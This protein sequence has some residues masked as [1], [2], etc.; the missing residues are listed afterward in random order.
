[1]FLF[2]DGP[3][4]CFQGARSKETIGFNSRPRICKKNILERAKETWVGIEKLEG[5]LGSR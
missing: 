2:T 4:L 5:S 3:F 1:M